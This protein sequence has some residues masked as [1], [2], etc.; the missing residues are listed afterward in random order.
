[1]WGGRRASLALHTRTLRPG[2]SS[3]Q[4]GLACLHLRTLPAAQ[5][6]P[7]PT[8]APPDQRHV[9]LDGAPRRVLKR[10]PRQ[11]L[12]QQHQRVVRGRGVQDD[13]R[14]WGREGAVRAGQAGRQALR[15]QATRRRPCQRCEQLKHCCDD[16]RACGWAAAC[17]L[18]WPGSNV[19][20]FASLS[21]CGG[22]VGGWVAA[23]G[24]LCSRVRSRGRREAQVPGCGARGSSGGGGGGGGSSC[25]CNSG[26]GSSGGGG[27]PAGTPGGPCRSGGRRSATAAPAPRRQT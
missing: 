11:P 15:V 14:G 17:A 1:M 19:A 5:T 25:G 4:P 21:D 27:A 26:G 24:C 20:R 22:W 2:H 7:A 10:V 13:L 16:P 23:R 18:T 12:H 3:P 6:T 9:R 8:S